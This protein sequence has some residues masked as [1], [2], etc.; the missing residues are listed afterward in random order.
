MVVL[1]DSNKMLLVKLYTNADFS[2]GHFGLFTIIF[3]EQDNL[4]IFYV[5]N[6][7]IKT[8]LEGNKY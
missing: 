4:Q 8:T 3:L 5:I 7:S 2:T 1:L 6:H